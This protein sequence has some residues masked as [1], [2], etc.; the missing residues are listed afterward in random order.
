MQISYHDGEHF[1]SVRFSWDLEGPVKPLSL[2]Q[3]KGGQDEKLKGLVEQ[4]QL[5]EDEV[6]VK[7]VVKWLW[8]K[9]STNQL[10]EDFHHQ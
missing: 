9:Q 4:A 10:M 3:L 7:R 6:M 2:S 1:N 5:G 8:V